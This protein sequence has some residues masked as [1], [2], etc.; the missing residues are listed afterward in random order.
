MQKRMSQRGVEGPEMVLRH[1]FVQ[2]QY[3]GIRWRWEKNGKHR[4][5]KVWYTMVS[6][7]SAGYRI[8]LESGKLVQIHLNRANELMKLTGGKTRGKWSVR[9]RQTQP[10]AFFFM[11]GMKLDQMI[12]VW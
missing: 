7:G 5:R 6:L 11:A 3:K 2:E 12:R 8:E 4:K 10:S 9:R 1:S